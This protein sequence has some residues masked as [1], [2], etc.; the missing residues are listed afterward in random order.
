[1][2]D[3]TDYIRSKGRKMSQDVMSSV[4]IHDMLLDSG[5]AFLMPN[6]K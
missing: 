4:W 3:L 1:M 2:K 5:K 6:G